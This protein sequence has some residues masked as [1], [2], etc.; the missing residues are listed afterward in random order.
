MAK[1]RIYDAELH[2]QFVTFSC[3]HRRRL[4]DHDRAKKIVISHLASELHR[5]GATCCGFVVM[6]DHVHAIIWFPESGCLSDFMKQWKQRSSRQ[7]KTLFRDH[8]H[9]YA[10]RID[11][12]EPVWQPGYYPFNLYT[13]GKA[14][15]KVDYMHTN[16]VKAG[17]VERAV[18]WPFGSAR[19]WL[20][21]KS[22]GVPIRWVF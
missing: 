17:L 13:E 20:L 9:G 4:L 16:P 21:G 6:P 2:A 12:T 10:D 18:D 7:I 22:V 15:E 8:L 11:P 3:F 19:Y 5:T 14:R 1:R